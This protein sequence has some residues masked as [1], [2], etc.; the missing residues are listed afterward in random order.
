MLTYI[1]DE[2]FKKELAERF[3]NL[4]N[5]V[6]GKPSPSFSYENIN[7][8]MTSL[9]DLKGK[10]VYIDV[11][12]TWCGPCIAEIPALKV[13]E[14]TYHGKNI[15]FVSISIDNK[16]DKEKWQNMVAEKGLK[17]V[18]LFADKD[19]KSDLVKK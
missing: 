10:Y 14:K 19:W 4:K 6:T 9:E 13:L 15:E 16:K 12:A 2:E 8:G 17:G 5:L 7:G 3:E 1:L 18:Q 11:W